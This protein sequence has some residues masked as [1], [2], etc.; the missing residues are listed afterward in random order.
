MIYWVMYWVMYWVTN[1]GGRL[2][3]GIVSGGVFINYRSGDSHSYGALL[4]SELSHRL[5]RKRVFLDS[6]SIPA[7]SD[8]VAELLDRLRRSR[9][10]LA[11]IGP[12]WLAD[13][14]PD[15]RRCIDDADDWIRR[16][17]VEAFVA[18]V[19]VIPVL[20][21]E[22]DL[23]TA[24]ELP[25]D[26]AALAQRQYR[27]LRHREASTDIARIVTDVVAA[28]P[29][30]AAAAGR[31]SAHAPWRSATT[32]R[33]AGWA[34]AALVA[35]GLITAGTIIVLSHD[36][37]APADAGGNP[38]GHPGPPPPWP[39]PGPP[40][41]PPPSCPGSGGPRPFQGEPGL[42]RSA[43]LA[44]TGRSGSP[45]LTL[46]ARRRADTAWVQL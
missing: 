29:D 34:A 27:R 4:H 20:T 1:N 11:V 33:L 18:G 26:I 15:G 13:I 19:T 23:P 22:A 45:S 39:P 28:Y 42:Q 5:G 16:E 36:A 30:L 44:P 37:A 9:V 35:L 32:V 21:D 41:G 8:F 6:E 24:E 31:G 12:R 25:A 10:L 17:L 38:A 43:R 3:E 2:R 7:G 46:A 40:P 14:G